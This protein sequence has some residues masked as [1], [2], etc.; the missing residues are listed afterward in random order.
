[1]YRR[2][3]KQNVAHIDVAESLIRA[4]ACDNA[5]PHNQAAS[6]LEKK[7]FNAM[8]H[9]HREYTHEVK[10]SMKYNIKSISNENVSMR[11]QNSKNKKKHFC[12]CDF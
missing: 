12:S 8:G 4:I 6:W 5:T 2:V 7:L 10:I 1:M 11:V 3:V 9:H